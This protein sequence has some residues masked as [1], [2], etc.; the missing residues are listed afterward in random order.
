MAT[1]RR[2]PPWRTAPRRRTPHASSCDRQRRRE[3]LRGEMERLGELRGD[4][5]EADGEHELDG[6]RLREVLADPRPARVA[7]VAIVARDRARDRQRRALALRA[8]R[9]GLAAGQA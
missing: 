8:L 5:L 1:W 7:H 2:T 3:S 4:G 9:I 6:L